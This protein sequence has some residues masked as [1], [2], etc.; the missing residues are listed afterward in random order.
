MVPEVSA[1]KLGYS[2][3][4]HIMAARKKEKAHRKTWSNTQPLGT[5]CWSPTSNPKGPYLQPSLPPD[6]SVI[7]SSRDCSLDQVQYP[8]PTRNDHTCKTRVYREVPNKNTCQWLQRKRI[9]ILKQVD[10]YTDA[11]DKR[12]CVPVHKCYSMT[13]QINAGLYLYAI[14]CYLAIRRINYLYSTTRLNIEDIQQ[15]QQCQYVVYHVALFII[16]EKKLIYR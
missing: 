11:R 2:T 15:C 1:G 10:R 7:N 12:R 4:D 16:F 13:D 5:H 9:L 3:A 6:N 8:K 14:K